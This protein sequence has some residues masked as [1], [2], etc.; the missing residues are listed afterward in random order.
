MKTQKSTA[1]RITS[2]KADKS[3][4]DLDKISQSP[5]VGRK[6]IITEKMIKDVCGF[7]KVGI[8]KTRATALAGFSQRVF[9]RWLSIA[10]DLV[11]QMEKAEAKNL[12]FEVTEIE[13]LY[14]QLMHDVE[15]AEA[16]MV[17]SGIEK[18]VLE[19]N[20]WRW[21]LAKIL[22]DEFGE[23]L[24]L[25]TKLPQEIQLKMPELIEKE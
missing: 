9:Y 4:N 15:V 7:I 16:Q 8:P 18:I 23:S 3:D 12:I 14:V 25:R 19:P 20:G 6:S 17:Q 10:S 22:P 2:P 24:E 21:V 5:A 1:T 13:A 11:E